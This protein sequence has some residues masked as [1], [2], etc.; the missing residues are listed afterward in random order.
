MLTSGGINRTDL[1]EEVAGVD[2]PVEADEGGEPCEAEEDVNNVGKDAE[3]VEETDEDCDHDDLEEGGAVDGVP[4]GGEDECVKAAEEMPQNTEATR[5][6]DIELRKVCYG[7]LEL[8]DK[9]LIPVASTG[10]SKM[11]YYVTK[12]D[13]DR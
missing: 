1:A 11:F 3:A 6:V 12:D 2:E 13:Y 9:N 4:V 5:G 8:M 10:D 7:I